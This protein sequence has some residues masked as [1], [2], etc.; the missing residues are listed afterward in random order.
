V[1][2]TV[3]VTPRASEA[4][5][6]RGGV[7]VIPARISKAFADLPGE[8]VGLCRPHPWQELSAPP[9]AGMKSIRDVLVHLIGAEAFWI[10]HV[11]AGGPRFSRDPAVFPD[12]DAILAAWRPQR[13]ATLARIASLGPEALR[14]RR[15]FPWN[16]Q[17]SASV[18]E[19]VWHVVT[20]EQYHRGQIF[21]RLALLGRRELPDYDM[22]R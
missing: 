13:R 9:A 14:D 19:I 20:H 1:R 15:A 16:P 18:E 2:L 11:V 21:T 7:V 3:L 10:G 5:G 22:L 12:L 17:E 8:I 4:A 6:E